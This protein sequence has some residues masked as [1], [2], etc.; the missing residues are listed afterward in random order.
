M[1]I[2]ANCASIGDY[3][4]RSCVNLTMNRIPE[5]CG[6]CGDV[7]AGCESVCVCGVP[8]SSAEDYCGARENCAFVELTRTADFG[9]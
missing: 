8:D 1:D 9:Y 5:D 2:P 7:F 6:L 4:F 3:A